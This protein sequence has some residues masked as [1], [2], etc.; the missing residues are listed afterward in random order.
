MAGSATYDPTLLA[1]PRV[2]Q[3]GEGAEW[4][5]QGWQLF[6][7]HWDVLIAIVILQWL[8]TA[9][10]GLVPM[11]GNMAVS[12]L[13]PVLTAGVLLALR[14]VEVGEKPAV[15]M[16]FG[17]FTS[18]RFGSLLVL[19][20]ANL[21]A[22]IVVVVAVV[23]PMAVFFGAAAMG[24]QEPDP[25]TLGLGVFVILAVFAI[26]LFAY[27]ALF[28]FAP[29]LVL[30]HDVPVMEAMK[31]SLRAMLANW[32]SLTIYGLLGM[33]LTIAAAFTLFL[34]LVVVGPL[35]LAAYYCSYRAIFT[36]GPPQTP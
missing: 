36:T 6:K 31:L 8:L 22:V 29:P 28:W 14:A 3:A 33:G 23:L 26:A 1:E 19:G 34:G 5:S 35:M 7:A 9:A 17:G 27:A 30:F 12:V 18:P 25:S 2:C 4:L 13:G 32:A 20:L 16:L 21:L 24:G 11:L 15:E 10:A